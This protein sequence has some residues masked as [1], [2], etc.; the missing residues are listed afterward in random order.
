MRLVQIGFVLKRIVPQGGQGV[1]RNKY[2]ALRC[3]RQ[4]DVDEACFT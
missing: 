2:I 1:T 3:S 4:P